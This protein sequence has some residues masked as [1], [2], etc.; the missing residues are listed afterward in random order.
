MSEVPLHRPDREGGGA[1]IER[2]RRTFETVLLAGQGVSWQDRAS[3]GRIW[4]Q[5]AG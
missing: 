4:C 2:C 3:V 1:S 5:P